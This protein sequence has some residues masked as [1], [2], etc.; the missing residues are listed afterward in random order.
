[1]VSILVPIMT[2]FIDSPYVKNMREVTR[3]SYLRYWDERNGGN[4]SYRLL[5][6]EVESYDDIA[7]VKATYE[8]GF[9][10]SALAGDYYLVTGT[11]RFF[12]N[13]YDRP[14]LDLGLVKVSEDGQSYDI[15]WGFEDG[16]KPTSEFPS[17]LL[18]HIER[19]K[20]NPE[21]RVI[22]HC[23]PTNLIAMSFTQELSERHLSRILWKMQAESIVVFPEGLG[24]IPYMT[25]GTN[26]IGKATAAKMAE[27]QAVLW[28]HHGLFASGIS[29]DET[30]GLVEV[31]EK[32]AMIFSQVGA[33]GGL[34]KQEI[35]DQELKE[36]SDFF[37]QTPRL[38][39]LDL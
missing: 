4:V 16:G 8:L 27:F 18:S 33:Q 35:T 38:D 3:E 29:L 34:I 14:T 15:V 24:V 10:A 23:H 30:Y 2:K 21:Q 25:P 11:G 17:H 39:S 36:I 5:A 37:G 12:R 7:G 6:E 32:A 1:M 19:L 9:N 31:I 28:P 20:I 22:F 26:E 13:I